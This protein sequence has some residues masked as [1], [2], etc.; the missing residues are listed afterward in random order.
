MPFRQLLAAFLAACAS[1]A[2]AAN[3]ELTVAP[4]ASGA[5]PV[6]CT[7][8]EQD[9]ALIAHFGGTPP[10]DFWEGKPANGQLRYISQIL[11]FPGTAL[12]FDVQVPDDSKLYPQFA[13]QRVEHVAIVCHPTPATNY[14]PGYVLPQT[15]SIVPHMQPAGTP[16]KLL[17]GR[18][19]LLLFSHGLGGSPISPG[20]IE[21]LVELASHGY[22]VAAVF[23]GDARFSRVRIEDLGDLVFLL[24]QFDKFA[25][26][27]L[28][29]PLAL[30]AHDRPHARPS[31]VFAPPST[32]IASAASAP[33]WAAR[34]WRISW[35]RRSP[36]ASGSPAARPRAIHACGPSWPSC[37]TRG[38]RSC[39]PSATTSRAWT[40][41][42]V[43][44]LAIAG[45]A[46]HHGAHQHDAP[47]DQPHPHARTTWSRWRIPHEYRPEYRGDIF[48]W[49]VAFL[50]A[51]LQVPSDPGAMARLIRMQSVIGR[52]RGRA[53]H[54][55]ARA[56]RE[57]AGREPGDRVLQPADRPL[58]HHRGPGRGPAGA[59]R[60]ADWDLTGQSF[61]AWRQ[62]PADASLAAVPVCRFFGGH[63]G[64]P[65]SHF[66]HRRAR[67]SATRCAAAATGSTRAS[68]STCA[69][70]LRVSPAPRATSPVNRAYNNGWVRN[71]SNHRFT[72]S[73]STWREMQRHGWNLEGT[74]MCSRP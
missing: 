52:A 4:I 21:A 71:D 33:A 72:T 28:M 49:T 22:I 25:E 29:R 37:R 3:H 73:D 48:T 6:A 68:T 15:N 10:E 41:V 45:T 57:H 69:A 18:L 47:G 74:V 17:P 58:L 5:L 14:D 59:E 11:R 35:A 66:Y 9:P 63:G 24:S 2:G 12:R 34:R 67:P 32:R 27:Q 23:H 64:G 55:R 42:G 61:K 54:R 1:L 62:P 20:H 16:P 40:R 7:N 39:R 8:V 46:G 31:A 43:P 19:P 65:N 70:S 38:R 36:P 13:D 44:F 60:R 50:N 30:K 51:Y 53:H 56:L 26:M